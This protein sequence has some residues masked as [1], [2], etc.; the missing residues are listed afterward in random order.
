MIKY[1]RF[2]S[3]LFLTIVLI[4]CDNDSV[5]NDNPVSGAPN[6]SQTLVSITKNSTW[7]NYLEVINF[8]DGKITN[9]Q[10]SDGPYHIYSYTNNLV[11]EIQEFNVS[12]T[13]LFTNTF[14]YDGDGRLV[15]KVV[16][17]SSSSPE[18]E[19]YTTY[20][21]SYTDDSIITAIKLFDFDD[22]QQEDTIYH[23]LELNQNN[24]TRSIGSVS[25]LYSPFDFRSDVTYID[26]NPLTYERY[27]SGN[28]NINSSYEYLDGLAADAYTVE[29]LKFGVHWKIN[30]LLSHGVPTLGTYV[31]DDITSKYLSKVDYNYNYQEQSINNITTYSYEFDEENLLISES[32]SKYSS[33]VDQ[34]YL[35]LI[36][37]EYE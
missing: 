23:N 5:T 27:F 10:F 12:G 8:T 31:L 7:V 28:L 26:D 24:V 30:S 32:Q 2:F 15:G 33:A 34:T 25:P 9:I 20:Q 4:S 29:K 35:T 16:L 19:N 14:S 21:Y 18:W 17:P 13:L 11:T 37:Y 1:T 36:T 3:I 6:N 22:V